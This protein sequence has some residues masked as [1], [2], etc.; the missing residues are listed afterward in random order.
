VAWRS[1]RSATIEIEFAD[2]APRLPDGTLAGSALTM[3]AAVRACLAAGVPSETALTAAA[4]NPA[5]LLGLHDR[6]TIEIGNRGD[7]VGL[8][9]AMAVDAVWIAGVLARG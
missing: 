7:L 6:G 2:G 3:D 1:R 5:R 8:S 9:D 4:T